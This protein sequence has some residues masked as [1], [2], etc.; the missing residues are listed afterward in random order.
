MTE[1]QD[2]EV[3]Q[4]CSTQTKSRNGGSQPKVD[5]K[6][7]ISAHIDDS[8]EI[9]TAIPTFSESGNTRRLM[10]LLSDVWDDADNNGVAVGIYLPP[11]IRFEI[12]VMSHLIPV[13]GYY[14][15]FTTYL[16]VGQYSHLTFRVA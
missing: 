8:D 7:Y 16:N 9:R 6:A 11:Y 15:C 10:R 14:F 12:Y 5:R 1:L 13:N 3:K 2:G 4:A